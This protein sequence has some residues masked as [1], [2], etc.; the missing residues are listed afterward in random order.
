MLNGFVF[1]YNDATMLN[2]YFLKPPLPRSST[3]VV[4]WGQLTNTSAALA[5]VQAAQTLTAPM[6]LLTR[7]NQQAQQY[8]E[9][10][11]FFK[12]DTLRVE[13]FPGWETLPYDQFSP[14]E[15]IISERLGVLSRLERLQRG[16]VI[17]SI[18]TLM[19]PVMAADYLLA[20]SLVLAV[21]EK[22]SPIAVRERLIAAGY[23]AAQQ[24]VQHGEFAIRGS[25]MDIFPMGAEEP[26]RIDLFDDEIDSIRTFD[27]DTQRSLT[28]LPQVQLLPAKEFPLT[29]AS[30]TQ[31]R[32]AWRE[33]FSGRPME[34]PLYEAI[35]Q[36]ISPNGIEYYL[37][38]FYQQNHYL[39]DYLP[40]ATT[41]VQQAECHSAAQHFWREIQERYEQY[42]HDI[43]RPLL[44]PAQL[45]LPVENV[46]ARCKAHAQI[47]LQAESVADNAGHYNFPTQTIPDVALQ[48]KQQQP[49]A[50]LQQALQQTQQRVLFCAETAGRREALLDLLAT[51][52]Q[53]PKVVASWQEFSAS[54]DALAI[55]VASLDQGMSL[56]EPALWLIAEAQLYGERV[57]QRRL[58]KSKS[59]DEAAVIRSLVEL[60][61]GM[62]VVHLEHGVGRYVGLQTL[63]TADMTTEFVA[64]EY[65]D[66]TKLYVPVINLELLSRYSGG[67]PD[68]APL[69]RLVTEQ[70]SK[71]KQRAAE[72]ARDVAAELLDLYARRAAKP[73]LQ[74][75]APDINYQKFCAG[76]P[77][78]ETPDQ[79]RA[80]NEVLEDLQAATPMDRLVCGDVGFGKTEVAMRAAFIAVHNHTQ[81]AVLVPTTL[82]AEQHYQNFCDRF[83]DWPVRVEMLSRFRSAK[84]QQAT[85]D[86]LTSGH[87]DIVIGTHKLLSEQ[88]QFARLGLLIIDEEHRFGVKQKERLKSLRT[89]VNILTLTAT[90][91]PRTLNL[92]LAKI[93]EL[94]LI[95]TPPAKR[96]SIKTFVQVDNSQ[97]VREAILREILRGGQVFFL[98][99][100]VQ[101]IE[102]TALELQQLVPEAKIDIGHGQMPERQLE[103]VM[104]DFYHQRFNVLL[105]TTIIETGIDIPSANTIIIHRADKFGLAQLHQLRGRVGRS[106]HQAYAY[107]L[108]P[109][110][111]LLTRDAQKRLDAIVEAEELGSGF[112]LATHDL[113]IRGA[114]E[115]LGEGQSGQIEAVGFSLYMEFLDYAVKS[116]QAG[117]QPDFSKPMIQATEI[118]LYIP[119]LIPEDYVP[120]VSQRLVLYKRI[121]NA[122]DTVALK[123]IQVE[124]IDRFG[125][126]P[127][128]AKNLFQQAE[129][130][131]QAKD[132]GIRK[133][134]LGS[135]GGF[136]EFEPKTS[137]EPMTLIQLLQKQP[138]IYKMQGAHKLSFKTHTQ[139]PAARFV[140]LE[141]LLASLSRIPNV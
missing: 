92:S 9:A 1:C 24:V 10:L 120:D 29:E 116:L 72:R 135:E 25:M 100:D 85:L 33:R 71:A 128:A 114:G 40:N 7:D 107:L 55:T 5:L 105:C 69:H 106:H 46:F 91:I 121:A 98:H 59:I 109:D 38:L 28:T 21:G 19:H 11:N 48:V 139:T 35:S 26:Y 140:W 63:T 96:L 23:R 83:A 60:Q 54:Q 84:E 101:T 70:W 110:P 58:R 16:I 97:V 8:L 99:N 77:F 103:R 115:L 51:I 113:E 74:F 27:P 6:L 76:F 15:D 53:R 123:D 34:C 31:F 61:P 64:I 130:K 137:I 66:A 89:D 112:L 37:P 49:L 47:R 86:K 2:T 125:L 75:A 117:K 119:T 78:E 104:T 36:G 57:M 45:F 41:I 52:D 30:I 134:Q 50:A 102:K 138:H 3:D 132:L 95:T 43:T 88:I 82:L 14:H 12:S 65:A 73:G 141:Q 81:V 22:F 129:L 20:H 124:M 42:G 126:L 94:S 13:L 127:P 56:R 79:A 68:L 122:S 18:T 93:R 39:F 4:Q 118:E 62:P 108:I 67:D 136:I 80:I 17:V 111:K 131:R 133:I 44:E 87:V 90:P 32:Q